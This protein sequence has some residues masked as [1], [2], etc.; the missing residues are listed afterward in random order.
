MLT[1][2]VLYLGFA[3]L[4]DEVNTTNISR[5]SCL[6][7][8]AQWTK[9]SKLTELDENALRAT[10]SIVTF[11]Y[12]YSSTVHGQILT[13]LRLTEYVL[14]SNL[15]SNVIYRVEVFK[16]VTRLLYDTDSGHAIKHAPLSIESWSTTIR[17]PNS[18]ELW[19]HSWFACLGGITAFPERH[20]N[21][22]WAKRITARNVDFVSCSF[23]VQIGIISRDICAS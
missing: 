20:N 5:I 10:T 1:T 8:G 14:P 9:E 2:L 17:C 12:S 4:R 6:A 16:D 15:H 13:Q 23:P 18:E 7:G 3:L 21:G 22:V 11:E 19:A